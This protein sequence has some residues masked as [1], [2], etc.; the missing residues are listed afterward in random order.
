MTTKALTVQNTKATNA[1]VTSISI[2]DTTTADFNSMLTSVT[3]PAIIM[4]STPYT[5]KEIFSLTLANRNIAISSE[6]STPVRTGIK[7]VANID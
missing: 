4:Q 6:T 2:R 5:V 3:S 1:S 7:Q